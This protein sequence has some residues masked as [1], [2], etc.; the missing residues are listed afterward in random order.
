MASPSDKGISPST[1]SKLVEY[2][3]FTG[4]FIWRV[5]PNSYFKTE[6]DCKIWNARFAG[7]P[8]FNCDDGRGY[9]VGQILGKK[10]KAHRAAWALHYG[11]WPAELIDHIN[12]DKSD[13]RIANLREATNS[14]NLMNRGA[15]V[16]NKSGLKGVSWDR[17]KEKWQARIS[18]QFKS[19][20]LG[21]FA[22]AEEAHSAYREASA[23]L[24]GEY[25]RTQ[26]PV[27]ERK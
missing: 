11:F 24:H 13:N 23:R 17:R 3:P 21:Y 7:N 5:R 19:R 4:A 22:T 6:R 2:N 27:G 18:R 26:S 15:N 14:Q 8:A 12:G 9:L 20:H 10:V 16:N 25:S 1:L